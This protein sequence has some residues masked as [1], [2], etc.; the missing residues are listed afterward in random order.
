MNLII[1][2]TGMVG[3]EICRLLIAEGKPVRAMVRETSEQTKVEKLE[4]L[5]IQIVQGDLRERSTLRPALQGVTAVITTISSMPF[6]YLA[7]ENDIEKVDHDGMFDLIDEARANGVNHLIYTS[8]SGQID[9]NFPLRNAKR[10]VEQHLVESGIEYTILRPSF[11]ME[12]WLTKSVGF[13]PDSAKVQLCGDGTQ[14]TS[15]ISYK[16]VAQFAVE[17]L[18]NP[19]AKDAILELGGPEQLS[20]LDAVMLFEETSGRTFEVQSIPEEALQSQM[21]EATDPMQ[22]SFSALMLCLANGDPIDMR[23][24]LETFPVKLTSVRDYVRSVID[25]T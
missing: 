16:D 7:G 8:F 22:Q 4:S 11:F 12:V 20:Q 15:Y 14:P 17:C 13:D 18:D 10:S 24:T 6:S 21:D 19:S 3:S 5:G 2:A 9:L 1:G 23:E 25:G